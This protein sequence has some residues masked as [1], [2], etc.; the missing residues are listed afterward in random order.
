[1]PTAARTPPEAFAALDA[2][3]YQREAEGK[4]TPVQLVV[5]GAPRAP[6]PVEW[7]VVA[8]GVILASSQARRERRRSA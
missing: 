2:V 8:D 5:Y 1:M 3:R 6:R 4:Y 7:A